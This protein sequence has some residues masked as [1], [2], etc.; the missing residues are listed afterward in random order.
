[1]DFKYLD[2]TFTVPHT[3]LTHRNFVLIPLKEIIPN[4]IHPKT[5]QTINELIEKL[6]NEDKKSILKITKN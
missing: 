3:K 2:Y 6:S 1:M 4:W 5:K